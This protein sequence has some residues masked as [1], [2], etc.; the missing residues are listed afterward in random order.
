LSL[1]DIELSGNFQ[2]LAA[3]KD[4]ICNLSA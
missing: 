2:F 3:F 1:N 4:Q